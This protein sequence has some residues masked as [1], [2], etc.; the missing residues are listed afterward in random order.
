ML[1]VKWEQG[2]RGNLVLKPTTKC[3]PWRIELSYGLSS[4]LF[5]TLYKIINS[6]YLCLPTML[7]T[8]RQRVDLFNFLR[9]DTG[10]KQVHL[11][12]RTE[13]STATNHKK[14]TRKNVW[15]SAFE[16]ITKRPSIVVTHGQL[17]CL[18]DELRASLQAILKLSPKVELFMRRTKL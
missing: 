8:L 12:L 14:N 18:N 1:F 2:G 15:F 16:A 9:R 3:N 5:L 11:S 4:L 6:P 7:K 17:V 13:P 10:T